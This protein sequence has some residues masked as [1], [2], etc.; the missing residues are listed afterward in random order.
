MGV[1]YS[2]IDALMRCHDTITILCCVQPVPAGLGDGGRFIAFSGLCAPV[3]MRAEPAGHST[4]SHGRRYMPCMNRRFRNAVGDLYT[5]VRP[6]FYVKILRSPKKR[7][8]LMI[9]IGQHSIEAV[10]MAARHAGR[11]VYVCAK[12]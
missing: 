1:P 3:C 12:H 6:P 11:Y 2:G 10:D 5:A 8:F 7:R 4:T 9:E